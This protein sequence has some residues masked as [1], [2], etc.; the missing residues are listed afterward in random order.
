MTSSAAVTRADI[1]K[2]ARKYLGAPLAHQGR[3]T[4]LDCVGLLLAV[5]EDLGLRD[6]A[7]NLILRS[8]YAHYSRQPVD[9]FVERECVLRLKSELI[10][11]PT[12]SRTLAL[13]VKTGDVLCLRV[14]TIACHVGIAS[15]VGS[16]VGVIHAYSS[17][18]KVVEH[19]IDDAWARRVAGVFSFPGIQ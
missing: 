17:A 4:A 5:A 2:A 12:T 1:V 10:G 15:N 3:H 7:G 19:R 18:H 6:L 13:L 11:A 9:G 14:P 8:D 16:D